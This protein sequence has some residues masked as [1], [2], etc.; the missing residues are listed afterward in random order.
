MCSQDAAYA[1]GNSVQYLTRAAPCPQIAACSPSVAGRDG[2]RVTT[3][4]MVM[5]AQMQ[6]HGNAGVHPAGSQA[7]QMLCVPFEYDFWASY[8][9]S[10]QAARPCKIVS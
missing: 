2:M 8:R 6:R 4:A 9:G 10:R 1:M 5:W 3:P 7:E